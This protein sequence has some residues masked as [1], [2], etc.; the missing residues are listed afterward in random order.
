[1]KIYAR[2][3][4]SKVVMQQGKANA[5]SESEK[6][7]FEVEYSFPKHSCR[8][9]EQIQ[10]EKI[11]TTKQSWYKVF[12]FLCTGCEWSER[13]DFQTT[14]G[15]SPSFTRLNGQIAVQLSTQKYS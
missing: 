11:K 5:E 13:E 14:L 10:A 7:V 15:H 6:K 1:M 9:L 12:F 2:N 4:S 8:K 3:F